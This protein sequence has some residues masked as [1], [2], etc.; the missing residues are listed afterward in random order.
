MNVNYSMIREVYSNVSSTALRQHGGC[1]NR[2]TPQVQYPLPRKVMS[3]AVN[4]APQLKR[5]LDLN[6]II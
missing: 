3:G 1:Q 6:V 5:L 4:N 2:L